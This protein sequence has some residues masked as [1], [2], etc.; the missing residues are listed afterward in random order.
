MSIAIIDALID[1]RKQLHD[2]A[3]DLMGAYMKIALLQ[4]EVENLK[5]QLGILQRSQVLFGG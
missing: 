3:N 4:K 5:K 2:Q 1:E